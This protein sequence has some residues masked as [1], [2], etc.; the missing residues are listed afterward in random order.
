MPVPGEHVGP[1]HLD[2][3]VGRQAQIDARQ[4]E[5]DG[6]GPPLALVRVRHEHDGLGHA[7]ALERRP[8]GARRDRGVEVGRQGRRARHAEAQPGQRLG[9]VGGRQPVPHRGHAEEH[10]AAGADGRQ[11]SGR[12]EAG[13]QLRGCSRGQRAVEPDAEAV[14]VEQRECQDQ[15]VLGRPPPGQ[16]H[17][18]CR[19]QQVGVA[20]DRTL[21][22]ARR[23][24]RVHE[25]RRVVP[26]GGVEP[27]GGSGRGG[28][29]AQ[30][31]RGDD[32]TRGGGRD[33]PPALG[34]VGHRGGDPGVAHDVVDLGFAV[35]PVQRHGHGA[36]AQH[37]DVGDHVVERGIGRHHHPVAGAD[38]SGREP[39]RGGRRAFVQG[40]GRQR[41]AGRVGEEDAVRVLGPAPP[42]RTHERPGAGQGDI[43]G[44]DPVGRWSVHGR[45][46]ASRPRGDPLMVAPTVRRAEAPTPHVRA[47]PRFNALVP[48]RVLPDPG[49]VAIL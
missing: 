38:P 5:A 19:R 47:P 16:R 22:G 12:I 32:G 48:V 10:R 34:V 3:T 41:R 6:A 9:P 21:R 31:G 26:G 25:Q 39:G 18:L 20:Q 35:G 1:A 28:E 8:P 17:G 46:A 40:S 7:V 4:R 36:Q 44:R 49:G 27:I 24:G 11:D 33:P 2:L 15:P 45:T 23:A 13:Q 29:P 14:H 42:P 43:A 30:I 37:A